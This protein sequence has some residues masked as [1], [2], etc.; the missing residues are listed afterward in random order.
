MILISHLSLPLT[1][2][3]SRDL[4]VVCTARRPVRRRR[5]ENYLQHHARHVPAAVHVRCYRRTAVQGIRTGPTIPHTSALR[6]SRILDCSTSVS[7]FVRRF[8]FFFRRLE[9]HKSSQGGLP[10]WE[11]VR[12]PSARADYSL[13]DVILQAS[14]LVAPGDGS[15]IS[16][17][18]D[19][20]SKNLCQKLVQVV[21][22]QKLAHVSVNLVQVFLFPVSCT[23]RTQLYS[24]TETVRHVTQTV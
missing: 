24:S 6:L 17:I 7:A 13:L 14:A 2:L 23:H 4:Y 21:L 9:F 19:T 11:R 10:A 12:T 1:A 3:R 16:C 5:R 18:G 20:R 8:A 22:Y 15:P